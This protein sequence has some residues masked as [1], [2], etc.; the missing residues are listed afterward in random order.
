MKRRPYQTLFLKFKLKT[1]KK[2]TVLTTM[3]LTILYVGAQINFG[4]T[5]G[6]NYR[7]KYPVAGLF[8]GANFKPLVLQSGIV[9]NV[10][11]EK[12]SFFQQEAGVE[13]GHF[14]LMGGG[15]YHLYSTVD[16]AYNGWHFVSDLKYKHKI[17]F[18]SCNNCAVDDRGYWGV[19]IQQDGKYTFSYFL[20]GIGF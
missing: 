9:N 15:S 7:D 17:Y 14:T 3:L 8:L 12:G 13:V 6:F 1:M 20:L 5:G 2:L 4:V 18:Q 16:K 11:F 10:P 19:V